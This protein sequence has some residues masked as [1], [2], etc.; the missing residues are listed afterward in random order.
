MLK[1][2]VALFALD[3]PYESL[4]TEAILILGGEQQQ[5]EEPIRRDLES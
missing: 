2:I 5:L 4:V 3:C 1:Q